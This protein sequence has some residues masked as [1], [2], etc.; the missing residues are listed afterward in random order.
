MIDMLVAN[1]ICAGEQTFFYCVQFTDSVIYPGDILIVFDGD[2]LPNKAETNRARSES[3]LHHL[4][5]AKK[6]ELEGNM[7]QA[8]IHYQRSVSIKPELVNEV[9]KLLDRENISYI[10]SPFEADAQLAYLSL[11]GFVDVVISEDSDTLGKEISTE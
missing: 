9:I 7:A 10:I 3:R 6:L 1:G 2:A 4:E 8:I 11:N 5:L